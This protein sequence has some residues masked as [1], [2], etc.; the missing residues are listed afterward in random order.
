MYTSWYR[1]ILPVKTSQFLDVRVTILFGIQYQ[2]SSASQ[3]KKREK[4]DKHY[5]VVVQPA[6]KRNRMLV[7]R[8]G[9]KR[10]RRDPALLCSAVDTDTSYELLSHSI[11]CRVGAPTIKKS[12][13]YFF[14]EQ[15]RSS[16]HQRSYEAI[17]IRSIFSVSYAKYYS[18]KFFHQTH[19]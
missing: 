15:A 17:T 6:N 4:K 18:C 11:T 5:Q 10:W 19:I 1:L 3:E 9:A 14:M 8:G 12:Y 13:S 2:L 16:A 7:S